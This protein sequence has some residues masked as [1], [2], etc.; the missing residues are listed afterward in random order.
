MVILSAEEIHPF[1]HLLRLLLAKLIQKNSGSYFGAWGFSGVLV[2]A[3]LLGIIGFL[4][5]HGGA[6]EPLLLERGLSI[7]F[8]ANLIATLKVLIFIWLTLTSAE[9]F[10]KVSRYLRSHIL[11]PRDL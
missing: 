1:N 10:L 5:W 7:S 3:L 6:L 9:D 11:A 8:A 4:T 2:K